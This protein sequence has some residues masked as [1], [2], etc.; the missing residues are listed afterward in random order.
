MVA[1]LLSKSVS[2]AF[3]PI[4]GGVQLESQNIRMVNGELSIE[5]VGN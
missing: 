3:K 5:E 2:Q 4:E 1:T